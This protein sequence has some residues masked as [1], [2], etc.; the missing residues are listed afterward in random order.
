MND[1]FGEKVAK[2]FSG[3]IR[4]FAGEHGLEI[5]IP[6]HI[7]NTRKALLIGE[8]A[9][10]NGKLD[11]YREKVMTAYWIEKKNIEDENILF[12]ILEE[13]GIPKEVSEILNNRQYYIKLER[14]KNEAWSQGVSGIPTVMFNGAPI[15]GAQQYSFYEKLAEKF[16]I[17]KR[18][19]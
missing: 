2:I 19:S 15:M 3:N 17:Q 13:C 1:F 4:K 14:I 8:F 6:V 11:M 16:N 10:E 9:R 7:H 12:G 5:E 18:A